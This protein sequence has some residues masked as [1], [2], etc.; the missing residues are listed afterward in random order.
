MEET[1]RKVTGSSL[2]FYWEWTGTGRGG[3]KKRDFQI[4]WEVAWENQQEP[5]K[6]GE[7]VNF[8]ELPRTKLLINEQTQVTY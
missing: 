7:A 8:M 3:G 6:E 4:L 1:G 2:Q 5:S